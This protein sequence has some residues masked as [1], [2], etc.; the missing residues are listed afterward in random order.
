MLEDIPKTRVKESRSN[1][2]RFKSAPTATAPTQ[3]EKLKMRI[4]VIAGVLFMVQFL[5]WFFEDVNHKGNTTLY[6]LLTSA[7]LFKML[8]WLHEWYHYFFIAAPSIPKS[9]TNWTVDM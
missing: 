5:W 4:L 3:R 7:L 9:K 6:W 1:S 2:V 8:R